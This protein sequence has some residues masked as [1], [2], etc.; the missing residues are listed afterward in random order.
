MKHVLV[1]TRMA[2][3]LLSFSFLFAN[4]LQAQEEQ[5]QNSL[6]VYGFAMTDMGY[7]TKQINPNW[8]DAL[9]ISKLPTYKDQY[10]PDGKVFFGVRQT[11]FGVQGITQ[12][13]MGELK[14]VFEFDLFGV[15]ADE[16]QTT[17]RLRHAYGELGR[18]LVGQTN[19]PFMDG[20]ALPNEI[21]YWGPTG[22]VF[23]RNVQIRY[24]AMKG[25]NEV[26][27]ALER[28]GASA[29]QGVFAERIELDSVKGQ[30]NLPDLSAH[31][32][33]TGS[34]GHVQISGMLRSIKWKDIHTTG[35]YDISGSTVGWGVHLSG[36][37]NL[38]KN[39]VLKGSVVYGE[40]IENYMND[41]PV[42][43][44]IKTNPGNT[45][46]PIDG[47]A[48]PVT[49][50]MA[51]FEHTWNDKLSSAIG[52]SSTDISNTAYGSPDAYKMGQ[53]ASVNI[54]STPFKNFMAAAEVQWG[55]RTNHT[56][57]FTSD[58]VKV[59]I[60]FKYNFSHVFKFNKD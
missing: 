19:T 8:F 33:R 4:I 9:R 7:E 50:I 37:I 18:W 15:G 13:S 31:Y 60:S 39:N 56:D 59:Q 49:G 28:P 55:K 32:K 10:A 38:G 40:G 23:F 30:F 44:G 25:K 42:D 48:L 11:R 6:E 21:E 53:Y 17:M 35:A 1:R 12:T 46:K 2:I 52:Y 14:S 27:I 51:Y 22:I 34:W 47:K 29:D 41:A 26:F 57:G 3:I 16:G 43:I 36:H 45:T 54:F 24:A 20:D 58:D 5:K